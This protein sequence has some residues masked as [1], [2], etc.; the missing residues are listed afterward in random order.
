LNNKIYIALGLVLVVIGGILIIISTIDFSY[1]LELSQKV[2]N[3][4]TVLNESKKVDTVQITTQNV[5]LVIDSIQ[6]EEPKMDSIDLPKKVIAEDPKKYLVVLG[7]FKILS[8]ANKLV[9]ELK[10][11]G[12]INSYVYSKGELNYVILNSYNSRSE[13]NSDLTDSKLDGWV[14]KI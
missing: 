13:A 14:K 2:E 1:E 3:R 9:D 8:N 7:T 11:K 6:V 12:F 4:D 5:D 10:Q